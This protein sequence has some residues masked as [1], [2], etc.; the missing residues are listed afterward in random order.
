MKLLGDVWAILL[1]VE[2]RR[3]FLVLGVLLVSTLVEMVSIGLVVPLLVMMTTGAASL[4]AVIRNR[5]A[6]LGDLESFRAMLVLMLGL[7]VVYGLKSL[8][9][10]FASWCQ[11]RYVRFVQASVSRRLF[12]TVLAQ[13]WTFHMQRHSA[14]LVHVLEETSAFSQACTHL[15]SIGAEAFVGI[16][17]LALLLWIEPVG[18]V[19]VAGMLVVAI[20]ALN[21][22]V[23]RR[24]RRWAEASQDHARLLRKE[25][26]EALA[27]IKE[28]KL[29]GCERECVD[30]FRLHSEAMAR[31]TTLHWLVEQAPRPWFEMI[32]VTTLLLL[33]AAMAWQGKPVRSLL[34]VLGLYA[35]VAFRMLPSI[36][37]ATIAAQRLRRSEPMINALRDHLAMA[38][39]LP[40]PEP[41]TLVGFRDAIRIERVSYRYP[42]RHEDVLVDIDLRIPYGAAVGFIG[43]SGAGKST[44]VDVI[45]GLLPP[46]S[47]R[48]TVDGFDIRENVRGWQ[49]IVGYVPQAIYLVDHSIRRNV[50]FG[51]PDSVIDDAAVRRAL[52]S[53]R[54][55]DFVRSLPDGIET[56]VGERG[57]RL[58]GGQRQRLAIARALYFD[59][60]VLVLDEA[61]SALDAETE[62]EV[63]EAVEQLHGTK[64]L[65]IVAHRL[66]TV[67]DCD[68]LY[69][70]EAGRIV[71]SG[72]FAETVPAEAPGTSPG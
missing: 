7:V 47:G 12:A 28:V 6:G 64:T 9:L 69:R 68:V 16:G 38:R 39:S 27:G 56:V 55:D 22:L 66:G 43:T 20:W 61:T 52:A 42:E 18:A 65:I 3:A 40:A 71:G 23:R 70:L 10:L 30:A 21:R 17:L 2:R 1:P 11:A 4:P 34:P 24:S 48:V 62:R 32:A 72:S 29:H 15:L 58:S 45:L 63:M 59:P 19:I 44:L 67:A 57:V 26:H 8:F 49:D 5:L 31:T 41:R 36:N 51:V 37:Q 14:A 54:L 50:A 35:T 46:T 13:P 53:A 60:L 25:V 33:T